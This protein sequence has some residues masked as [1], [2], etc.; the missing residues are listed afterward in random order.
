VRGLLRLGASALLL[1]AI[2]FLGSLALWVGIPLGWL[3]IASQ[4][5]ASTSSLGAAVATAMIGV[6]ASIFVVV[7]LLSRLSDAYRRQRVARGLEDTGH[8]AL[9]V[10]MVTSAA[11]AVVAFGAWFLLFS[12]SSPIPVQ[13][14]F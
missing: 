12:G 10:V 9:E 7:A 4:I 14:S 6:V 3:W 8:F 13:V 1:V 5:E 2:M 11:V